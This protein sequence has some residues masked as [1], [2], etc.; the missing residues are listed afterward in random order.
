MQLEIQNKD[1][2]LNFLKKKMKLTKMN[3]LEAEL[4]IAKEHL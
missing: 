2:E 3:E 1:A 4:D